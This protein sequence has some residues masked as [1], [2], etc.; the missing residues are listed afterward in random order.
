M[1]EYTIYGAGLIPAV[2]GAFL[3]GK[4]TKEASIASMKTGAALTI[5]WNLVPK[6]LFGINNALISRPVAIIVLIHISMSEI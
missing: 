5:L 6:K 3:W 4:A 1:Y 2:L